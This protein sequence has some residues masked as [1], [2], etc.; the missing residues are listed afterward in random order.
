MCYHVPTMIKQL[1]FGQKSVTPMLYLNRD[2]LGHLGI[3]PETDKRIDIRY[4]PGKIVLSKAPDE[5]AGDPQQ[6]VGAA[7]WMKSPC[8]VCE[9]AKGGENG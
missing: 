3:D 7:T 2:M 8:P 1:S 9:K 5:K 6:A 4:E